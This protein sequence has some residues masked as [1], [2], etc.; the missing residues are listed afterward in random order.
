MKVIEYEELMSGLENN[1]TN[2]IEDIALF[3]EVFL[4]PTAKA[5][6]IKEES[7]KINEKKE[8]I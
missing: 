1:V 3:Y 5:S 4:A 7:L 6:K 8:E 2:L